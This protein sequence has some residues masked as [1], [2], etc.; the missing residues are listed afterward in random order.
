MIIATSAKVPIVPVTI[1]GTYHLLE[2]RGRIHPGSVRVTIHKPIPT[3]DM[4]RQEV[5]EL[6]ERVRTQIISAMREQKA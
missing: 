2:E 5:R 6:P 3:A 4:S 1:E